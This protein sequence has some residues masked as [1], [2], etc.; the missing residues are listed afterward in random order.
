[1][2]GKR[3]EGKKNEKKERVGKENGDIFW[4]NERKCVSL[5]S[6]KGLTLDRS[7]VWIGKRPIIVNVLS[8]PSKT[9]APFGSASDLSRRSSL[10]IKHYL[11]R[12]E[13]SAL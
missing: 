7:P 9:R 13:A 2:T 4:R 1:M 5:Q 3:E 10:S 11:L 12:S 6:H 8:T